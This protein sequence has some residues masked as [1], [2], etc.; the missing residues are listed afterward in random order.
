LTSNKSFSTE[1]SERYALALFE[2]S[3]ENSELPSVEK[4]VLDLL[5]LYKSSKELENFIKNPTQLHATQI[6]VIYEISKVMKFSKTLKNFLSILVIKRRIF[7]VKEIFSKFLVLNSKKRGE[8]SAT[9][10]SSKKLSSEE[11]RNLNNQLSNAIGST[12][13]FNY[14]VDEDLIGGF[15]VQIGSLMVDSSIKNKLK[16]YEKLMLEF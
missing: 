11:I 5:E 16:K 3:K 6:K 1:T 14:K 15:K 4:N 9:L 7:Y 2:L 12:V 13:V 8:L 10:T